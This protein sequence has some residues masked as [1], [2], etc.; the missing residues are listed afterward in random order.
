MTKKYALIIPLTTLKFKVVKE[1]I[2]I[3]KS[4]A[5]KLVYSG[6]VP[7]CI[8]FEDLVAI[9]LAGL[10]PVIELIKLIFHTFSNFSISNLV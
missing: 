9:R 5:S 2:S 10:K 3:I 7:P 1:T 6:K 8:E 4:I